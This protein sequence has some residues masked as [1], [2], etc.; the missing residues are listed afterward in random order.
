M[1]K[2]GLEM[3]PKQRQEI[4][5]SPYRLTAHLMMAFVTFGLLTKTGFDLVF[6]VN[7]AA[8][9]ASTMSKE[10]LQH[11]KKL[12]RFGYINGA[13]VVGTVFSGAFVAGIDAGFAYNTFPK[14]GDEWLPSSA[15]DLKPVWKNLFENTALVQFDHRTLALTTLSSIALMY[16]SARRGLKGAFWKSLPKQTKHAFDVVMGMAM[17]Q[18]GLG[19]STLLMYVPVPL[20]AAHQTGSVLLLATVTFLLSTLRFAALGRNL[21]VGVMG[22]ATLGTA[23][24]AASSNSQEK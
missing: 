22:A 16:T 4:R 1:V 2:S 11:A 8:E 6:P 23:A 19:I 10:V 18:V 13:L 5:V 3:D 24:A 21:G 12:R 7:K 20:A 15:F 14:M 17:T 9:V